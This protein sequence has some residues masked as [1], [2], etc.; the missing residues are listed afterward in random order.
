MAELTNNATVTAGNGLGSKTHI[1]AVTIADITVADACATMQADYGLTVAG[2]NS[3]SDAVCY[4]AAQGANTNGT[5]G[6]EGE[7]GIALTATFTDI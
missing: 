3:T 5:Q 4:V 6:A 1:F 2:V 7:T